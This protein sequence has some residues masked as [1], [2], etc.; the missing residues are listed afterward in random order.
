MIE[1]YV[2][3]VNMFDYYYKIFEHSDENGFKIVGKATQADLVNSIMNYAE[4]A[5]TKS[6]HLLGLNEKFIRPFVESLINKGYK[7]AIDLIA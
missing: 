5:N 2:D 3:M 1:I 6:I 7:V 4:N